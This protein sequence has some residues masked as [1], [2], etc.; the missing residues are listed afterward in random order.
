MTGPDQKEERPDKPGATRFLPALFCAACSLAAMAC[1]ELMPC[2]DSF[3][4]GWYTEMT[5]AIIQ[6]A[7]PFF[8]GMALLNLQPAASRRWLVWLGRFCCLYPLAVIPVALSAP[9]LKN[10]YLL[11][12]GLLPAIGGVIFLAGA[13][14]ERSVT[15]ALGGMLLMAQ[16]S[17]FIKLFYP[18]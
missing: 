6:F 14:R 1:H 13:F 4:N 5:I 17:G 8:V 18:A 15:C 7:T 11:L 3:Y 10:L 12:F 16:G 9:D 2:F